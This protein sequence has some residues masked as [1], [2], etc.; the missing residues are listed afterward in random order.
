[1]RLLAGVVHFSYTE[2]VDNAK[3]IPFREGEGGSHR[4]ML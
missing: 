2:F 4:G 1:M 3:L